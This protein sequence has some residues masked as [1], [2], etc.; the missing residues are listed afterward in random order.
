[1]R[2]GKRG[3]YQGLTFLTPNINLFRDPRWGRG[4]ETYGEDPYL[5]RQMAVQFIRGL[6]GDDPN[7]LKVVAT[8]KHY[9]VHSGPESTRHVADVQVDRR[10][11]FD[12]YLPQFE[13]AITEGKAQ[14]LMCAYNN[15][16][17][18]PACANPFLLDT[19]LRQQWRFPGYV[20][21]DC[22]AVGD[23]YKGHKTFATAEE[24]V[25]A[26]I[27]AGTDLNCGREY[28]HIVPA[29]RQGLLK[30]SGRG[31]AAAAEGALSTR[32]VRSAPKG[33]LGANSV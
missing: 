13:A 19:I 7:Y 12:S 6:Q 24:G 4:M 14:S 2:H 17:G 8:A 30:E 9:T 1:V 29:V 5:T 32:D 10:D 22:G 23:V 20:V 27:K 11:L 28:E 18:K 26:S 15:V 25:A 21:S 31:S 16:D 3:I 33:A